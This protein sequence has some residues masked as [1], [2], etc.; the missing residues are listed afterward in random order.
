L[1]LVA[2]DERG[3]AGFA[4]CDLFDDALHLHELDVR[5]ESQGRGLGRA[6]V[7]AAVDLARARGRSAVTLTTF[8]N[9]PW[10]APFYGQ[11]GFQTVAAAGPRLA[12]TLAAEAAR[13]LTQRCAM[14]RGV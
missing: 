4:L 14:R 6:L 2:E 10:N 11:L 13:G 3:V 12:A 9:I 8:T 1:I 7:D 5:L